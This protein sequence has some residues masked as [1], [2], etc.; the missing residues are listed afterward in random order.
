M[1]APTIT[2]VSYSYESAA[3]ATGLSVSIIRAAARS[4]DLA[5]RYVRIAGRVTTKPVIER[6]ELERWVAEGSME[7]ST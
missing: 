7:R 5:L 3:L 2:P 6:S 1:S 4:G